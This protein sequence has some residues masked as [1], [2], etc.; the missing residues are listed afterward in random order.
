MKKGDKIVCIESWRGEG[1]YLWGG[2]AAYKKG[3]ETTILH[4]VEDEDN[5]VIYI[6]DAIYG[7]Y[8]IVNTNKE[9]RFDKYF[10]LV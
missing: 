9:P 10:K 7:F 4:V 6:K 1:D 3:K 5:K 8:D 2:T